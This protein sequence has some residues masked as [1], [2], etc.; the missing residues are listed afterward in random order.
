MGEDVPCPCPALHSSTTPVGTD[1]AGVVVT[2]EL[3]L[4]V[5][6]HLICTN[7]SPSHLIRL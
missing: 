5:M 3:L 2:L 7:E 4:E 6:H 1:T